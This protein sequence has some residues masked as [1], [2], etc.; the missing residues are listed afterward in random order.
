MSVI[1]RMEHLR[2][3]RYCARGVRAFFQQHA[4]DYSS[5]LQHGIE[6][7]YLLAVTNNDAMALAA[8]EVANERRKQ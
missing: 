2:E 8:V 7:E 3:L 6:S 1:V 5:F 4:L